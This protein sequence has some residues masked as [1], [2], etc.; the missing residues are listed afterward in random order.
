MKSSS[1]AFAMVGAAGRMGKS[2]IALSQSYSLDGASLRLCGALESKNHPQLGQDAGR[3]AALPQDLGI[4]LTNDIQE[5]LEGAQVVI[6]FSSPSSSLQ[7]LEI[8][9]RKKLPCLIGTTGLQEEDKRCVQDAAQDIAVILASNTSL[10]V[11][12]LLYLTQKTAELLGSGFD[13]E[14]TEIHHHHKKDAP[15]GTALSL[16]DSLKNLAQYSSYQ[17]C[18]GRHS[19][20]DSAPSP[21]P[22]EEIGIHAIRGGDVV[23]EHRIH[24]FGDGER[25][26]LSHQASSRNCFAAGALRAALFL[27][28][29]ADKAGCY[30]MREVLGMRR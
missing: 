4:R 13:V 17:E 21:R 25:L 14:I 30:S 22:R 2:I 6:D 29:H 24:F 5:A 8:C 26:E 28:G 11:N 18:Y 16:R 12:L 19:H 9:R 10:G 23:G 20:K 3:L 7:T 15:S 27:I 1:Y